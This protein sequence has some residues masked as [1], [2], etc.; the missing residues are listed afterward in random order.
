MDGPES[1]LDQGLT[2][3]ERAA[4]QAAARAALARLH[5]PVDGPD[6]P[7]CDWCQNPFP[8]P[9][10]PAQS[11]DGADVTPDARAGE[12]DGGAG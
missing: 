3:Q 4:E 12:T 11:A 7:V 2:P 10:A 1:D 5:R 8:C 6:G 9:H